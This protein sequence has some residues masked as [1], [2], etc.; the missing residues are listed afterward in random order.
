MANKFGMNAE[1]VLYQ[2]EMR[3]TYRECKS[4]DKDMEAPPENIRLTTKR[5]LEA[6]E[7]F[8]K[9]HPGAT[10]EAADDAE[11]RCIGMTAYT[12]DESH[13][14]RI[15][16]PII[17]L[18]R[19]APLSFRHHIMGDR[20]HRQNVAKALAAGQILSAEMEA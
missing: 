12:P 7:A 8:V 20:F 10:V 14:L 16:V 11:W 6:F 15:C 18:R 3:K 2:K 19:E 13:V 5:W 1:E 9:E 4:T 17:A